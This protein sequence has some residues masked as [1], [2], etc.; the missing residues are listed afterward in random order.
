MIASAKKIRAQ[1]QPVPRVVYL[2]ERMNI[3]HPQNPHVMR[4]KTHETA[5]QRKRKQMPTPWFKI[6][7]ALGSDRDD[8]KGSCLS[9][10][11]SEVNSMG[12]YLVPTYCGRHLG[13]CSPCPLSLGR[14]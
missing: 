12:K 4:L 7:I 6:N 10:R 9:S 13:P 2:I 8:G 11:S 5:D 14:Q 3:M 1:F